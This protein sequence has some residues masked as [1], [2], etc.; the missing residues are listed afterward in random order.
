MAEEGSPVVSK[1]ISSLSTKLKLDVNL[2]GFYLWH[3]G[4]TTSDKDATSQE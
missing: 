2:N 3:I 1:Y 4:Q